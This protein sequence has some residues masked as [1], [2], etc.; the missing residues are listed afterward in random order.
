MSSVG[1]SDSCIVGV[2][3]AGGTIAGTGED[4]GV[5]VEGSVCRQKATS[6][7]PEQHSSRVQN[8]VYTAGAIVGPLSHLPLC[9]GK[10]GQ[11]TP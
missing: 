9:T 7:K 6:E 1:A 11:S 4:G 5:V 3:I 10:K 8:T 2:G